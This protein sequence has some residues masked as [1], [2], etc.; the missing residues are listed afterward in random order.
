VPTAPSVDVGALTTAGNA[1]GSSVAA[2]ETAD[3]TGGATAL[4]S[5][6]I[7]EILGYGGDG[8]QPPPDKRKRKP[9]ISQAFGPVVSPAG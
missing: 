5:I 8:S 1:A 7:V 3:K 9:E 2:A 4:P 6:W